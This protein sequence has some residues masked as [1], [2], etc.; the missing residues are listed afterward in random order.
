MTT[1]NSGGLL[2]TG[3]TRPWRGN[4]L[5]NGF[6][7][8]NADGRVAAITQSGSLSLAN[9]T[10]MVADGSIA[11]PFGSALVRRLSELGTSRNKF[12]SGMAQSIAQQF[13]GVLKYEPGWAGSHP[14]VNWGVPPVSKF[15]VITKGIVGYK[16]SKKTTG[17][18]ANYIACLKG[19]LTNVLT[20]VDRFSDWMTA[21]A[22]ATV[23]GSNLWLFFELATGFPMVAVGVEADPVPTGYVRVAQAHVIEPENEMVGFDIGGVAAKFYG[24]DVIAAAT[25]EAA[26]LM[27]AADKT[28]L[29]GLSSDVATTTTNGLMSAADKTKL[30]GLS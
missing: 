13:G 9:N 11:V 27:S 18:A 12:Y 17:S 26:G 1:H 6:L 15:T 7:M 19:D 2:Q 5:T 3:G 4:E 8:K 30:D 14:V 20:T 25:T 10:A 22:E 21:L 16:F 23:N 28:K 29:D 24:N